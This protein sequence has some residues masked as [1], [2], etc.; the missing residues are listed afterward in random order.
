MSIRKVLS[1]NKFGEMVRI[2]V[3]AVLNGNEQ[4]IFHIFGELLTRTSCK[5]E[6]KKNMTD[7]T[8][9]ISFE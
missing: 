5:K 4:S 9:R 3:G 8:A 2:D 1:A 7:M 6:R